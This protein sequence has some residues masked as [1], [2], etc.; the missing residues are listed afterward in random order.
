MVAPS[1]KTICTLMSVEVSVLGKSSI[2]M[3]A[4]IAARIDERF[5]EIEVIRG[6]FI[7]RYSKVLG[8]TS[9]TCSPGRW[10]SSDTTSAEDERSVGISKER[11][12]PGVSIAVHVAF[13][14]PKSSITSDSTRFC[15]KFL[16]RTL[17]FVRPETYSEGGKNDN[18][19]TAVGSRN[20]KV[21]SIFFFLQSLSRLGSM[22][23]AMEINT[24]PWSSALLVKVI[25]ISIGLPPTAAL[26]ICFAPPSP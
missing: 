18:I 23:G 15:G 1:A 9:G 22:H 11:T 3:R 8:D 13:A 19:R 12:P 2:M 10:S 21:K 17:I 14:W 20:V 6:V 5:G 24:A 25:T 16:T 7:S 26:V 4:V